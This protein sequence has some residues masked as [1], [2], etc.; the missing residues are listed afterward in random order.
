MIRVALVMAVASAIAST[1]STS[2]AARSEVYVPG[3]YDDDGGYTR[4]AAPTD[5]H[6]TTGWIAKKKSQVRDYLSALRLRVTVDGVVIDNTAHYWSNEFDYR[7]TGDYK[8][9]HAGWDYDA[10]SLAKK[11]SLSVVMRFKLIR[12]VRDGYGFSY[13]PGESTYTCAIKG[14]A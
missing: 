8:G 13:G 2:A 3:C 12:Q 4:V 10:G 6:L 14:R 9:W 5:L 1:G 7:G 11:Q